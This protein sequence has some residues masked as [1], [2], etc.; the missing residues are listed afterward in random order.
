MSTLALQQ[1]IAHGGPGTAGPRE[2]D[3]HLEQDGGD[4]ITMLRTA[5][6]LNLIAY[7]GNFPFTIFRPQLTMGN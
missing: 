6:S 3:A 4:R 5:C 7:F 1:W 2:E